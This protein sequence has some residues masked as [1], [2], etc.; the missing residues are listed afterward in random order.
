[1]PTAPIYFVFYWK[2]KIYR[3]TPTRRLL[4]NSLEEAAEVEP[5]R[6]H[7]GPL[8]SEPPLLERGAY[9]VLVVHCDTH[10]DSAIS[11]EGFG[12]RGM[13]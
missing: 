13:V 3:A 2:K 9:I 7:L 6:G 11:L 1:M 12:V 8:D 4:A 10:R 5:S